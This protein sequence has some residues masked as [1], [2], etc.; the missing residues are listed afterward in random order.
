MDKSGK[1][2]LDTKENFLLCMKDHYIHDKVVEPSEVREAEKIINDRTRSVIK[3]FNIGSN[4]GSGQQR[5]CGRA[6]INN[7]TTI[8]ALQGLRKDHKSDIDND[9]IKG[10]F[11][12]Y[13]QPIGHPMLLLETLLQR[14]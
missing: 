2:V 4:S 1:I 3:I 5:R 6:L 12:R 14:F 11:V 8:P 13:V 10:P 9:P 7:F